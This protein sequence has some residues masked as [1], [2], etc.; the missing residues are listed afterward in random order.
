MNL[1]FLVGENDGPSG[2]LLHDVSS[3]VPEDKLEIF[4]GLGPLAERLRKKPR[5]ASSAL[6]VLGPSHG[7]LAA[8]VRLGDFLKDTRVLLVLTDQSPS[9][10]A[11][12]HRI[13]PTYISDFDGDTSGVVAVLRQLTRDVSAREAKG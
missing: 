4:L 11:L 6:L 9:T 2:K 3:L 5:D 7:E 12:A 8:I 13:K 10:I 1:F